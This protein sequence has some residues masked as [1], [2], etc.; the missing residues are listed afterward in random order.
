MSGIRFSLTGQEKITAYFSTVSQSIVER[1]IVRLNQAHNRLMTFIKTPLLT[2]DVLKNRTG[3]L[4]R[5]IFMKP[6]TVQG[7]VLSGS[8]NQ[9]ARTVPYGPVHEYGFHGTVTVPTHT[10][11]S[12]RGN[13]FTVR[14]YEMR[15]NLAERSFMRYGF[16]L[17]KP[18]IVQA[19]KE[20]V[21]EGMKKAK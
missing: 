10:R 18:Q 19:L 4:R 3:A 12:S 17:Q 5:S 11:T 6:A 2:G 8:V 1:L 9:D 16:G 20:G 15:M 7:N 21:A 13:P 14:T